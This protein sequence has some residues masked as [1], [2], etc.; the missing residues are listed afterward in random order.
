MVFFR[1]IENRV[2]I[3]KAANTGISCLIDPYGRVG[4]TIRQ[5]GEELFVEGTLVKELKILP[6]GSFYTHWGDILPFS[7]IGISLLIFLRALFR[8]QRE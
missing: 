8:K 4:D 6:A 2:N 5:Q 3:V 7:C 1:A